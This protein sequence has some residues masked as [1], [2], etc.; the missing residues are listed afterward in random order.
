MDRAAFADACASLQIELSPTQL[1]AF[2]VFEERLYAA[3]QVMNLTR[4]PK[5]ECWLRHFVDSLLIASL[6]PAG[7]SVLD[8]GTGPGF[9]AWPLGCARPDLQVTAMDSSG[10]MLGFLAQMPL[11]NLQLVQSRAEDAG[12][13][14]EF[15]IVTGRALAPLPSQMELSAQPA[16]VGGAVI[17]MR[18]ANEREAIVASDFNTLGLKLETVEEKTLP[19]TDI[20]RVYPAYRK[21]RATPKQYPRRWAEIR[22]KP[23]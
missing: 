12:V 9:P 10:K 13:R 4:V 20:V 6:I 3:N 19:G 23:L 11:R 14:E 15:D 17:P 22:A 5:D 21:V 1:D 2:E 8:I 16:R 18:S 7:V